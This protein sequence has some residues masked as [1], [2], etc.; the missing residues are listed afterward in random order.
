MKKGALV[1]LLAIFLGGCATNPGTH[2]IEK[3]VSG[4]MALDMHLSVASANFTVPGI[5]IP[6][7][8]T[9]LDLNLQFRAGAGMNCPINCPECPKC[10]EEEEPEIGSTGENNP[11]NTP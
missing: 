2:A 11:L 6:M 9:D 7:D 8:V 1:V 10:P 4:D 5:L 3:A